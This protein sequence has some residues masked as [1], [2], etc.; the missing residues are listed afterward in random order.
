MKRQK[1]SEKMLSLFG[2]GFVVGIILGNFF[3]GNTGGETGVM[4]SYFLSKFEYLEINNSQL[5]FYVFSER[6][7]IFLL[8]AVL[9]ITGIGWLTVCG[10]ILWIGCSIGCFLTIC[11]MRL[12]FLGVGIGVISFL[13]Q[14]M[15]YVPVYLLLFLAVRKIQENRI[16][17]KSEGKKR[18]FVYAGL[19]LI[20]SLGMLLGIFLESYVN[21]Y[22]LKKILAFF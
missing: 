5:F 11:V 10:Y 16:L 18:I 8:L 4:S 13:P 9:G 21:P 22:L 7:S 1:N 3:L 12:G 6:M 14:Y 19:I 17:I 2:I 15:I 20:G